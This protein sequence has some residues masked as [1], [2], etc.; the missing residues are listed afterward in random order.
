MSEVSNRLDCSGGSDRV[1][2][3]MSWIPALEQNYPGFGYSG[4]TL[5]VILVVSDAKMLTN[6]N[7]NDR[8]MPL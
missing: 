8:L 3:L 4:D 5:W 2:I 6:A 7:K 1:A